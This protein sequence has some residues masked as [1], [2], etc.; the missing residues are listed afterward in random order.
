MVVSATDDKL[1]LA[2]DNLYNVYF[3]PKGHPI[4]LGGSIDDKKRDTRAELIV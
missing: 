4:Q 3:S 1:Q 2:H